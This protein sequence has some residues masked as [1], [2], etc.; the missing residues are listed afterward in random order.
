MTPRARTQTP[1]GSSAGRVSSSDRVPLE[2]C[3]IPTFELEAPECAR[4]QIYAQL[5][6]ATAWSIHIMIP[7]GRGSSAR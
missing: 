3:P 7:A 6:A 4:I 2:R 5:S 1:P